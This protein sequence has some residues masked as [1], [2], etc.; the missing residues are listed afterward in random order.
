MKEFG[1]NPIFEFNLYI[2]ETIYPTYKQLSETHTIDPE[3]A[4]G[5]EELTKKAINYLN[6]ATDEKD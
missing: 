6:R 3:I 1:L 4:N 2:V 5:I